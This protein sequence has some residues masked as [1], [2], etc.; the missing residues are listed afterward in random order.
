MKDFP[1]LPAISI[2]GAILFF[3]WMDESVWAFIP[4]ALIALCAGY[5][6][7]NEAR[8]PWQKRPHPEILG[9][10]VNVDGSY[11]RRR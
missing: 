2:L 11:F 4:L 10:G 5:Y 7:M 8:W 3:L 9:T 1:Y 6:A